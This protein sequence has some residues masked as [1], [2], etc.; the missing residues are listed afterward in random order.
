MQTN[1]PISAHVAAGEHGA[2]ASLG[3]WQRQMAAA[4]CTVD[5]QPEQ[6]LASTRVSLGSSQQ[7]TWYQL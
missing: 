6:T 4:G 5:H 3:R 7:T 2:G 1:L